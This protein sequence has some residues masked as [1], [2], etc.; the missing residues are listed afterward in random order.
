LK[1]KGDNHLA[2]YLDTLLSKIDDGNLKS[3]LSSEIQ[4]L[5]DAKKFGLVF[6]RHI[7]ERVRLL[8]HP[9]TP[10]VFVTLRKEQG[11]DRWLVKTVSGDV[12]SLERDDGTELFETEMPV[13]DLVVVRDF[14]EAIYPGLKSVG[15]ITKNPEKPTNIAIS[16]ENFHALETLL[17]TCEN[18]LDCIYVDPPYNTGA[19]DWKYNN[20]FV[21][22]ND[23]YR[24]SRWLSF[25]EKRLRL[26]KRLLKQDS[27]VLIITIDE[28]EYSRL[29]LLL[30]EIFPAPQFQQHTVS[31]V[32]N[33]RG[34]PKQNFSYIDE[35]I[36]F[37]VPDIGKDV[38]A[39]RPK[40]EE[41]DEKVPAWL[42]QVLN[43]LTEASQVNEAEKPTFLTKTQFE[44]L[45][46]LLGWS[47][48]EEVIAEGDDFD[49]WGLMRGGAETSKRKQRPNQFY[50]IYVDPET[51]EAKS[52]GPALKLTDSWEHHSNEL[53]HVAVYPLGVKQDNEG[54]FE[55]KAWRYGRETMLSEIQAGNVVVGKKNKNTGMYSMGIKKPKKETKKETTVWTGARYD[56]S[57][58][59][60][61]LVDELL[62]GTGRFSYPKSLY[63]V[64]D[65]IGAVV[66]NRPNA[67]VLDFFAGS[68][69]TAHAVAYLNK[70]DGGSRRSIVV[71]NNEVEDKIA[72]PLLQKGLFPGD[73]EFES[74]GIFWNATMPRIKAAIEGVGAA[75]QT[76][77]GS[78]IDGFSR[79]EGFDENFEFFELTY[80]DRNQ[81]GRGKAFAAVSPLLWLKAGARGP[82][83]DTVKTGNKWLVP[84]GG[85][86]AVLFDTQVWRQ[87]LD[88]LEAEE[89][90]RH[91]FI[92]TNALSIFQQV[93]SELPV[94]LDS[95]MLYEDYISTFEINT[96]G[97]RK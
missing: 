81:I 25:M 66:R 9:I 74:H 96:G 87:F 57:A 70:M 62:G 17:Y 94:G 4:S 45:G 56:A 38:I 72:A 5:R 42:L 83:V 33:P 7:P 43:K 76:L 15:S 39:P 73:S 92:V 89:N 85:C 82:R 19:R 79:A 28:N 31:C 2:N 84:E 20:D 37:V 26:S 58:H 91:V 21:D 80:Q 48:D 52:L 8:N 61:K 46:D 47:G 95:T 1:S 49:V 18:S 59:G 55:E 69:T 65:A 10:G 6:E 75:G 50:A 13:K 68:G 27:G 60:T 88:A 23:L 24:H 41:A 32:I 54:N 40:I 11:Q 12:A 90:V 67:V 36:I 78:Y 44:K 53:G 97:G 35:K 16:A 86:Y 51:N 34:T 3:A 14:G 71:T 77:T 64:A 29:S 93:A 22:N 63:S 30:E